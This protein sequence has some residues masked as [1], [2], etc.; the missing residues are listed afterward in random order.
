MN[1]ISPLEHVVHTIHRRPLKYDEA[2][3]PWRWRIIVLGQSR[4]GEYALRLPFARF[5]HIE[6]LLE[7]DGRAIVLRVRGE[8]Y[9]PFW[10]VIFVG[11]GVLYAVAHGLEEGAAGPTALMLFVVLSR[12]I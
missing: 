6:L 4:N 8:P 12:A 1:D 9:P 7:P 5:G 3:C 10:R 11:G 2:R